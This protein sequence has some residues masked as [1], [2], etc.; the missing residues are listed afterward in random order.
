LRVSLLRL[1]ESALENGL[2]VLGI[3]TLQEM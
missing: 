2:R 1:I 3:A